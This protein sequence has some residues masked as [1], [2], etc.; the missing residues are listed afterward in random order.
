MSTPNL[1]LLKGGGEGAGSNVAR[2][3]TVAQSV[4][5]RLV[6]AN[7]RVRADSLQQVH[8]TLTGGL[9]FKLVD[10]NQFAVLA[11]GYQL[12][13]LRDEVLVRIKTKGTSRRP[14]S[15]MT[16]SLV[17]GGLGWDHERAKMGLSGRWCGKILS[18]STGER[19]SPWSVIQ[20]SLSDAE[21]D[22]WAN[23]THF[24]FPTHFDDSGAD[25]L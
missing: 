15:H 9:H 11:G 14:V 13:Y 16:I 25:R 2:S 6:D 17:S 21:Q 24:D 22:A 7:G 3:R 5:R 10:K 1:V 4:L 23:R 19:V 18:R 8:S 20:D 12:F